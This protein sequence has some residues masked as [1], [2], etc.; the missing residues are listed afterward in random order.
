VR[1][2]VRPLGGEDMRAL[3][4]HIYSMPRVVVERTRR[5]LTYKPPN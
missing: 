1:V 2:E 3:V 4:T 5:A